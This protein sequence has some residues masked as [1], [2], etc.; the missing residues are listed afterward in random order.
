[1]YSTVLSGDIGNP[2]DSTDN[3]YHVVI[4]SNI[5]DSTTT[6]DGLTITGGNANG[7]GNSI[8]VNSRTIIQEHGSGIYNDNSS[9]ILKNTIFENNT[10]VSFGGGILG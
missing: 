9:L 6:L 5:K 7:N 2:N 1:M 4:A 8:I 10:A 3:C